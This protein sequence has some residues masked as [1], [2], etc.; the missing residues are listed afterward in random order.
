MLIAAVAASVSRAVASNDRAR[1]LGLARCF[2]SLT[3]LDMQALAVLPRVHGNHFIYYK[4]KSVVD[5]SG[6]CSESFEF[7]ELA[8]DPQYF[9]LDRD[10][11]CKS[12]V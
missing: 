5:W 11:V 10:T 3:L 8:C 6:C 9:T 1:V 2:F 12:D 4:G 7:S